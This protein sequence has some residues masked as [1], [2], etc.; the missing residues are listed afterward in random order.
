LVVHEGLNLQSY[1]R[2]LLWAALWVPVPTWN[3]RQRR[4]NRCERQA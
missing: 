4:T 3:L 2:H 1:T